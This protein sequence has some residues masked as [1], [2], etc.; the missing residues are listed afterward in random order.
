MKVILTKEVAGLGH[1]GEVKEV[2][3]GYARN[4]LMLRGFAEMATP[5]KID[6]LQERQEKQQKEFES[7]HKKWAEIVQQ[8]PDIHPVFKR[9]A[10]KLGKL[11]AGVGADQIALVLAEQVKIKIDPG[12]QSGK[13]LRLKG[14]GI[15]SVNSWDAKGDFLITIQVWTPKSLTKEEKSILEKLGKSQNFKPNP[16]QKDRSFFSRMKNYFE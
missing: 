10:S 7:L 4:F 14:K 2:A 12:T 9:K 11:F 1:S 3:D 15:P 16:S 13:V 5:E 6:Q 8:L